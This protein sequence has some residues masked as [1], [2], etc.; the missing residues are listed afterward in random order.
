MFHA[1]YSHALKVLTKPNLKGEKSLQCGVEIVI[2]S[3]KSPWSSRYLSAKLGISPETPKS[4][5]KSGNPSGY[6]EI[7]PETYKSPRKSG[8]LSGNLEIS[9]EI[10]KS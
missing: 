6:L 2:K 7:L 1:T 4:L 3:L 10:W 5:W 8:N 9:L